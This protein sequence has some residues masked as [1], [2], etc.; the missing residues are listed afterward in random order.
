MHINSAF[1][2]FDNS[3]V[4]STGKGSLISE[5]FFMPF[6][7]YIL[8]PSIRDRYYVVHTGDDLQERLRRHNSNH[9]GFTGEI[10]D[11]IIVYTETFPTKSA[12][13]QREREIKTWKSRNKI[14]LLITNR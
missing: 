1:I 11:W 12:A 10:G 13:Y 6:T 4:D 5:S 9:K 7:V 2:W 14:E 8:Y 3:P